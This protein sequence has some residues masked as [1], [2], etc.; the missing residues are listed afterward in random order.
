MNECE[1]T[2]SVSALAIT[3]ANQFPN[4]DDLTLVAAAMTQLADTL[5][6]IAIQRELRENMDSEN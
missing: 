5:N 2:A 4:N 3:I 1:L 6:T